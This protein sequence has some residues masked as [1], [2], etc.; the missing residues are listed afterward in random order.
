MRD[1]AYVIDHREEPGQPLDNLVKPCV[2]RES[3]MVKPGGHSGISP[4]ELL[5][6][7]RM[8]LKSALTK[9]KLTLS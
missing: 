4:S 7:G 3:R 9:E 2:S 1:V 5:L 8:V 6:P